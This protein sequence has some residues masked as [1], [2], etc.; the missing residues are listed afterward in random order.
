M[1]RNWNMRVDLSECNVVLHAKQNKAVPRVTIGLPTYRRANLLR[2]ALHSIAKQNYRDFVLIVSDNAGE[3]PETIA[4]IRDVVD[5]MPEVVLVAQEENL[6]SLG[7][8]K[9]L[10]AAAKTEYFMWLSDDDEITENY[11][12]KMVE[13]LD[14]DSTVVTAM[15]AWKSMVNTE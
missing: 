14:R 10:L 9:F 8:F 3:K 7:N 15:G 1:K 12:E 11:L 6:T 13:M 2:R 4:A 5:S